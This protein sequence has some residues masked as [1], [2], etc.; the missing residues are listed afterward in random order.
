MYE[1]EMDKNKTLQKVI[2]LKSDWY[3]GCKCEWLQGWARLPTTRPC[4]AYIM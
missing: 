4:G 1:P 3:E 2:Q